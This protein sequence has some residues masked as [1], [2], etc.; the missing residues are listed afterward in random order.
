LGDTDQQP[1]AESVEN[2]LKEIF[3]E[4]HG[5]PATQ[6]YDRVLSEVEEPM[7]KVVMSQ[8]G[9]NQSRAAAMLGLNRGTL[10]KKLKRYGLI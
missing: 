2:A 9:N 1:L 7:L 3:Q 4:L 5:E 10:R 8:A 6:L